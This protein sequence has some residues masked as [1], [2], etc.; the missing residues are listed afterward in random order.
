MRRE[1]ATELA[2]QSGLG[3]R[4]NGP[5]TRRSFLA[6]AAGAGAGLMAGGLAGIGSGL[7]RAA[8]P[9]SGPDESAP[10]FE[11][12]IPE[13]QSR[14]ASGQFTSR[15]LTKAY[16][17][18]IKRLNPTLGAVIETNPQA[19]GIAARRDAERKNGRIR[20]PLHG[21][22]VL[23]KDNIATDDAMQT[24]AGSL[25]LVGTRVPADAPLVANLRAAGAVI[26]GKTNLSE[27]A[28]FRGFPP[29]DFPFD[30]N[31]LNGWSARGGFTHDPYLLGFDPC[32]SSS[33]SGVA[34]AVNMCAVAVG[35]E[36]DGS[37]VCPAG[38]NGIVGIKPTIG[39][40]SQSGIIPIAHSQDSAGPMTRTVTDAAI[41]L[42]VM[43]S[44]FGP[45]AGHTL[46]AD[47][48][49]FLNADLTG[50]RIGIERRQFEPEYFALPQIN[51]EVEKAIQ[52]MADAGAVIVDPVDTG[53]TYAWFDAEFTVLLYEF[54]KDIAAY[55]S[56]LRHTR[57]DTRMRTLADL[58]AFNNAHCE[59]EME[60]FGQEIFEISQSLSGNLTDADY[61]NARNL[62]LELTQ[63]QGIDRVM[64]EHN[65]DAVLS[66]SYAFGSSAPAAA[67]YPVI[68]VPVGVS[69]EGIPAGAWLY[70]GFL[71]EPQLLRVAY[72]IE[73]LLSPREQPEF[74]GMV[75][76]DPPD[77]GICPVPTAAARKSRA[78][79]ARKAGPMHPATGRRG[80]R[81]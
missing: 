61:V 17:A 32:G 68:S 75:P 73:Q 21:I 6:G 3:R 34:P 13:L 41:M 23:L 49:A 69:P 70:A 35:T 36:T 38:N 80:R 65:L 72:G 27:W 19:V 66:P 42:N 45:V 28:N 64:A 2:R 71:Q 31:Y 16:L 55:L 15:E 20:G 48:T 26:L 67:G 78:R 50:L 18:R 79:K 54:K 33:G 7:V 53:D 56:G 77:A 44:P 40:I 74:L 14:M 39:L 62:C 81:H 47:Y 22:P 37:I 8:P 30:T 1:R 59:E 76:A 46:P 58:I 24:T 57:R 52:A 5:I 29:A 51:A 4:M 10:W 25:A 11:R 60:F 43:K 63:A 12:S 9:F